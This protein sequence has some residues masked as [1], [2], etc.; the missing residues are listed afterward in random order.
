M[1][2]DLEHAIGCNVEFKN[3]C[4]LHPNGREYVK[5][6]GGVVIIG[7]LNDPHE[8]VFLQ[9]HNDFVTCLAVSSSGQ[10][11]ATGQ[12][13]EQA[14]VIL[15]NLDTKQQL[16]TFEEQDH[17]I[18]CV[19]FSHDDRF[20]FSCGD[21]FDKRV[22]VYDTVR[23]LIIAWANINPK[24]TICM[25]A[26]GFVRDIKRRDTHEYLVAACGGKTIV[27][28]HLAEGQG[29]LAAHP[30]T[31]AGREVRE[32]AC[33][34][35][36]PDREYLIAGTTTGDIAVVLMKNRVVQNFLPVCSGGVVTIACLFS[37]VGSRIIAGG[38]DGTVTVLAGANPVDLHE[39]RQIR[40]DGKVTSL[41]KNAD[42]SEV[43]AVSDV[44]AA[45]HLRCR[46]LSMK[47]HAQV[48]SGALYDVAYPSGISELFLTCC[49]DGVVTMW[50]A[51]DYSARLRCP[52]RTRA[53]PISVAGTPDVFV[54]G[55]SDGRLISFDCAQG[56]QLW[57]VD[58]AHKGG[59][60]CVQLASNVR[61]V[62]TGGNEG[63]VRVWDFRTREMATHLKEHGSRVNGLKLFPGD[64]YAISASRD[65]CLLTWDLV[66][67]RRL[68]AH[69]AKHGGLNCVA[70][71]QNQTTVFTAS[72]E[73]TIT[74]WDLRQ[75]D[76][77]RTWDVDEEVLSM[78]LSPDNRFLA[79]CGT[80][81]SVRV[82]DVA[83]N[84]ECSRGVGHSRTV[85]RL[86]FS[87]DGKQL[88]SVGL[89]HAIMMWN[90]YT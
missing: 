55:Y 88:V 82:W 56:M 33:M 72:Q 17:G 34:A 4:H 40:M 32:F 80:G 3:I 1:S 84:S 73:K 43:L 13:G 61:F 37:D 19:C 38:G 26:G 8:Q 58:D 41:A 62:L 89:D 25:V 6:V 85:Q 49:A 48:A 2:I 52:V 44:G 45:F 22:F 71:M 60:T 30:V 46:D 50:D 57:E 63:E 68:T 11:C 87:P 67:Q 27:L 76:P 21:M 5:A 65:R 18:D 70:V 15:W 31:A 75:A 36:T 28:W 35:F 29:S 66:A 12:Q 24:P 39:E 53:Y 78:S 81:L 51:N 83:A 86:A 42:G 14:D 7:D 54:A 77:V 16:Y 47:P 79:T 69:R 64:Q 20:L 10:L 74:E 59:V 9:G 90:F 23:F